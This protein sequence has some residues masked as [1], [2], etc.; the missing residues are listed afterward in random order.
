LTVLFL[1]D[2]VVEIF[3][4]TSYEVSVMLSKTL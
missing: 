1:I 3:T 2:A 4:V